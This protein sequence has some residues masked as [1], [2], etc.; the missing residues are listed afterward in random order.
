MSDDYARPRDVETDLAEITSRLGEPSATHRTN[1]RHVAWRITLGVVLVVG[2]AALH[3]VLWFGHIPWPRNAFLWKALLAGLIVS[4]GAGLYLIY[5]AVRGM[6]LWVLAYPSGLF[7]WHRGH[8]VAYPWDEVRS[9]QLAGLPD[10]AFLNRP[11][12][13]DGSPEAIWYDLT[14]SGRRIFGTT[15]TLTRTD[16][17]QVALPST[18]DEFPDLGRR[19]Q[20]ETYRRLF[21]YYWV[22]LEDGRSVDF[23]PVTCDA[24]GI[25]VGKQYLAWA[26][27]DTL[28]RAS[29]KLE[30]KQTGK[31]KAW[32]KIDLGE[33]ANPHVL[34]GIASAARAPTPPV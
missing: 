1:T 24:G 2:S 30:I 12:G 26:E 5:F 7:V 23:G 33:I 31:K 3:Y 15:I 20:E 22:T 25:A 21:P 19:V 28:E 8:V 10:K 34:M 14:K 11:P 17:E 16:G 13:P 27:V 4:P 18:L 29:D 9:V 32:A 6:K